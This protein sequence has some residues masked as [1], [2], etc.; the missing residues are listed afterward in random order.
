MFKVGITGGIGSGKSIVCEI[1]KKIGV[2]VYHADL[3]ARGLMESNIWIIEQLTQLFGKEI[4]LQDKLDRKR[5]ATLIFKDEKKLEKVNSIVHPIVFE[6]FFNW[7]AVHEGYSYVIKEA[8]L[9]FESGADKHLDK[10]IL[11][12]ASE[13]LRIKRVMERDRI[14]ESEVRS[15]MK[16]QFCEEDKIKL[17]DYVIINDDKQLVIPQVLELH[18]KFIRNSSLK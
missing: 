12:S 16:H 17:S 7:I 1:F 6:Q 11:I 8:A 5:L 18:N 14:N 3:E 9:I 15:R 10:V 2:P 4:Y 13:S